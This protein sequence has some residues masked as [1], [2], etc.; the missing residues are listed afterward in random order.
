MIVSGTTYEPRSIEEREERIAECRAELQNLNDD[1][2]GRRMNESA[3]EA[4]NALNAEMERHQEDIVEL[5]KRKNRIAE[6]AMNPNAI[7]YGSRG[8]FEVR[9]EQT[10]SSGPRS[11]QEMVTGEVLSSSSSN[12]QV[13]SLTPTDDEMRRLH[14]AVRQTQ[15]LRIETRATV[16]TS[17]TG[18]ADL[19]AELPPRERQERRIAVAAGLSSERVPG[20]TSAKFPV[21][22]AGDAGTPT[23]ETDTKAEYDAITDGSA[24]PQV[25][26]IWTDFSRQ[27]MLTMTGFEQKLRSVQSA[28]VARAEDKVLVDTVLV[29]PGIQAL[30]AATLDPDAVLNAAALVA[31]SDVASEPNL[32]IAHPN[33][34]AAIL[35]T[36]VGTGGS[37]SPAFQAF[38]PT[39]HGMRVYP[40]SH[41][42]EGELIVGAWDVAAHFVVGIPP[43]VLVDSLSQVKTNT[44]TLLTE[45]AIALAIDEPSGFVWVTPST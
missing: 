42:N 22:G 38:L 25:I 8:R 30:V 35:G 29:D 33:D 10:R 32:V 36:N 9:A 24:T 5:R 16:T 20:V 2:H 39:I 34:V 19:A 23:L 7:E 43:T 3:R 13:P 11:E 44:V 6:M 28:K 18:A 14:A 15:N 1:W 40:S 41:M 12:R 31:D 27:Q 37:A 26:A 17:A 4:W 45:E 21:F